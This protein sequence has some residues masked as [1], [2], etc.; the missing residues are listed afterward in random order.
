MMTWTND[1]VAKL[2]KGVAAAL[3]V[4]HGNSFQIKAYENAATAIEHSTQEV[5]DLWEENNLSAIPGVGENLQEHLAELFKTGQVKHWQQIERGLP[6]SFFELLDVPGIG[7]KIAKELVDLGVTSLSDLKTKLQ[8][9]LLFR[10]GFSQKV[11]EKILESLGNMP[12]TGNKR[13][14]LNFA[15][16]QAA[17]I[18]E[19]L[20]HSPEVQQV[21]ALG[22]LRRMVATIGDLDFAISS[23]DPAK[24]LEY[25]S[26]LPGTKEIIEQGETKISLVNATNLR[27]DFLI[28]KPASFGA[29]LQHFTG[30]K[31]HNIHLRTVAEHQGL[32]LSE[33][34]VRDL[35]KKQLI[36]TKSEEEFYQLLGMQTPPPEI[37]EDQGEIELALQHKLPKLIEPKD[38]QGDLHVHDDFKIEPSH[39][40]GSSSLSKIVQMAAKLGYQYL[41]IS[42]HN[43]S[44]GNHTQEQIVSLIRKHNQRLEQLNY[45][46]KNVRVLK[47]LEVDIQP[48]GRLAVP[49]AGLKLLDFA[50]ASV[51]SEFS[52]NKEKMTKRLLAALSNPFVKI[53]GHPT[54]RLINKRDSYDADWPSIFKLAAKNNIAIEINAFPDRLD[55]PDS[56]IK[57]AKDCGVKFVIDTDSHQAEQMDNMKYGV[58]VARRGWL[59]KED[60]VNS[61]DW[62]SFAK[63]FKI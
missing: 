10:R 1:E 40:L 8:S 22:S 23:E 61:W 36:P 5:L 33:Y 17:K 38:M 14:L 26:K 25:I 27:I 59:T 43:P 58:A 41:G 63:W 53:F 9:G 18:L 24:V 13:M 48:D 55:L 21:E 57:I 12:V 4:H 7:P 28:V 51:H 32:S 31:Q 19:Y 3:T 56:L 44:I 62:K 60:I 50:I 2:L 16:A 35:K 52:L 45:S 54:G 30:S 6:K 29:L 15:F 49:N 39:D 11:G 34:G 37:R 20:H 46:S 42:D 47:L